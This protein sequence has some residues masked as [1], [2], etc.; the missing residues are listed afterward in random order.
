MLNLIMV[1]GSEKTIEENTSKKF[2]SVN[3][4]RNKMN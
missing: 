1:S 4:R 2:K 3:M